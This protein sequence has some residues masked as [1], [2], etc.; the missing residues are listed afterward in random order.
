M[1]CFLVPLAQAVAVSAYRKTHTAA[2]NDPA[3]GMLLLLIM[4]ENSMSI[5]LE[6]MICFVHA[7]GRSALDLI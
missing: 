3:S 2:V 4:F 7:S 5:I 1:C 6:W